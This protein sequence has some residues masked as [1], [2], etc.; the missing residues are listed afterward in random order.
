MSNICEPT[1]EPKH[2]DASGST[3]F[4]NSGSSACWEPPRLML[5]ASTASLA[6]PLTNF[7]SNCATSGSML[8]AHRTNERDSRF[9]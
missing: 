3:A 9:I 8:H 6:F 2:N 4:T 7:L 1:K 5:M